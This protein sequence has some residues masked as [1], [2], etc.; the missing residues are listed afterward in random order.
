MLKV[1]AAYKRLKTIENHKTVSPETRS[2]SQ[3]GGGRSLEV[4]AVRLSPGKFKLVFW[5][6]GRLWEVVAYERRSHMEVLLNVSQLIEHFM[7][8]KLKYKNILSTPQLH[9]N[10]ITVPKI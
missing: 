3:T 1:V 2:R 4:P 6:G 8:L 10:S 5:T 7:K 9:F